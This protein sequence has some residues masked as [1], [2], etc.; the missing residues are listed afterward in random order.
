MPHHPLGSRV[1]MLV[2]ATACWGVGT[3]VTKQVLDDV[4]PLTLLPVQLTASCLLLAGVSVLTRTRRDRFMW[5]PQTRGLAA[6]GV[7]NPASHTLS[8]SSA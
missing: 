8:A 1:P 4:A 3:V 5:S 2:A 7:L 6:L